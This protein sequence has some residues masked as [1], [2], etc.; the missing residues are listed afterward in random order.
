MNKVVDYQIVLARRL[1]GLAALVKTEIGKG[2]VPSGP[3]IVTDDNEE[4]GQTMVKFE[5]V[6][7]V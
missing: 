2:W 3:V 1:S 5:E 7:E 4:F 6:P